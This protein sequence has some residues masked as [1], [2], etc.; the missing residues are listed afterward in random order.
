MGPGRFRQLVAGTDETLALDETSLAISAAL[1]PGLDE[2]HWLAELD[3]IAGTCPSPTPDSIAA[4]LFGT[5]GFSGNRE[6]YYDWRNSCLDRVIATR[7]GIPIS[8][9][10]LMIEVGRRL[11]VRLVGV[12]MP[13]HFLVRVADDPERFYDPFHGARPLGPD[14]ARALFETVTRG[15]VRWHDDHLSPTPP[16]DIVIRMLNNL[17]MVFTRRSDRVRFGIVMQLRSAIDALALR[18]SDELDAGIGVFN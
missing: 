11:G 5:L 1:Q 12:G 15:Q 14:E 3:H 8:L 9:S 13:A 6:A 17:K 16:L 4:H 18:E 10:V 2:L 7:T